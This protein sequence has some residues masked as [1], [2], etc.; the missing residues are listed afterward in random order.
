VL[1]SVSPEELNAG[2]EAIR[3]CTAGGDAGVVEPIDLLVFG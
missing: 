1:A 3:S 2:L